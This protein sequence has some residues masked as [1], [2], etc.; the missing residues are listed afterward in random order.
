MLLGRIRQAT[1]SGNTVTVRG[2]GASMPRVFYVASSP[3]GPHY[4]SA[5]QVNN[6]DFIAKGGA[7]L[8]EVSAGQ[9]S[10]AT[11]VTFASDLYVTGKK[12]FHIVW[13]DTTYS[14]LDDWR[15]A[16]GQEAA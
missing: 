3:M 5:L 2:H 15:L 4:V 1:I 7:P 13:G 11:Q 9:L 12:T 6:N 8:V 14:T 16:T 10:D